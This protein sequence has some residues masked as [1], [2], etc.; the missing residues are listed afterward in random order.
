MRTGGPSDSEA[1]A[2]HPKQRIGA[3]FMAV[4]AQ[5]FDIRKVDPAYFAAASARDRK[6][7]LEGD[8]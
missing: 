5:A 1:F 7:S 4:H 2:I 8:E 6:N 3:G